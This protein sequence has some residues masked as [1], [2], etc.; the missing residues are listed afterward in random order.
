VVARGC[1]FEKADGRLCRATPMREVAFCFWHNPA[2]AEEA[3]DA[4]R[5]GGARR[6]RERAV[7][8][9]YDFTGLSTA[10]SITRLLEIAVF[11]ALALDNSLARCRTL[12]A[13]GLAAA[14]LLETGD[15]QTRIEL[16]ESM[17]RSRPP[18]PTDGLGPDLLDTA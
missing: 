11:D 7:A 3:A 4:R 5:L 2:T 14:K 10:E 18:D 9:A 12:I 8:G 17:A 15:L 6:R 16:L 1:T 13:A